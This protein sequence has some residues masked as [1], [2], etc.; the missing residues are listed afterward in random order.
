[1]YDLKKRPT[2]PN[3]PSSP[4]INQMI[5][6]APS[7]EGSSNIVMKHSSYDKMDGYV[8][9]KDSQSEGFNISESDSADS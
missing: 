2:E 4:G 6:E 3:L 5:D 1:M 7:E 9:V 8:P